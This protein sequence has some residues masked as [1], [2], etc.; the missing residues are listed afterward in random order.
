GVSNT[1]VTEYWRRSIVNATPTVRYLDRAL[2]QVAD[3]IA[4]TPAAAPAIGRWSAREV[5]AHIAGGLE[6]YTELIRGGMSPAETIDAIA[7][8]NDEIIGSID[9]AGMPALAERIRRCANE[10]RRALSQHNGDP[11][12]HWHAGAR[13]PLSSLVAISLG[14]A[15]VHGRDIARA[16]R[17]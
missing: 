13:V 8:M 7:P 11:D 15:V 5:A 3:L 1:P 6:L 16:A 10:Y 14:E 9:E 12:I 17:R 4:V 2:D